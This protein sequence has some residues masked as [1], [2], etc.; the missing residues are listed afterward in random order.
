MIRFMV[1]FV[2]LMAAAYAAM[3]LAKPKLAKVAYSAARHF[4]IVMTIAAFIVGA[5]MALFILI[6][7]N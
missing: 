7:G 6:G 1:A 3:Y 4:L 5:V 2:V